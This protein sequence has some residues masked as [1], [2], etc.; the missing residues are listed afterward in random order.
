MQ[1]RLRDL[2]IWMMNSFLFA[3]RGLR[4]CLG[5]GVKS[6]IEICDE[7]EDANCQ[8]EGEIVSTLHLVPRSPSIGSRVEQ[9]MG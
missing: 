4:G 9:G 7:A 6:C 8:S 2:E 3:Q 1:R 5:C